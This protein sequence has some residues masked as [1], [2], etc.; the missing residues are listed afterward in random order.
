M[1]L[2]VQS[3]FNL[4]GNKTTPMQYV[5]VTLE[6]IASHDDA[7]PTTLFTLQDGDIVRSIW[8]QVTE[9]W[10]GATPGTGTIGDGDD[11][12][13]FAANV[14]LALG[15]PGYKLNERD[16]RGDYLYDPVNGHQRDKI[17]EAGDTVDWFPVAN[18]S[19]Q[20]QM[21]VW[22]EVLRLK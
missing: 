20:G 21:T 6:A 3:R 15:A 14:P 12:D 17:Y 10:D 2:P 16:V 1:T 22:L 4:I 7:S 13:G 19:T 8:V 18:D 9:V 11:V 5:S